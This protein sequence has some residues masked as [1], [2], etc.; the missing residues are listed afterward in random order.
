MTYREYWGEQE[1]AQLIIT[2]ERDDSARAHW[3]IIFVWAIYKLLQC[4]PTPY[5]LI[6]CETEFSLLP[7]RT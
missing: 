2:Q 6:E 3:V 1:N 4:P 5:A 7:N